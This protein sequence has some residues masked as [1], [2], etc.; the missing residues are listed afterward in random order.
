M[1]IST[2]SYIQTA[3]MKAMG[4]ITATKTPTLTAT[5][6]KTPTVTKTP[7]K[8][9]TPT[10][11]PTKTNTPTL[12]SSVTPTKT[13]TVDPNATKTPTPTGTTA[14]TFY[15]SGVLMFNNQLVSGSNVQKKIADCNAV[16]AL[17]I[18]RGQITISQPY[19]VQYKF[20]VSS[21][22]NGTTTYGPHETTYTAP[23]TFLTDD[24]G[25]S[26]LSCGSYDISFYKT[27]P[28]GEQLLDEY[29]LSIVQAALPTI[30]ST[31]TSTATLIPT[32]T[33]TP[34]PAQLII[35]PTSTPIK[36]VPIG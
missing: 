21:S 36:L 32:A 28:N 35:L 11:T 18:L 25:T 8:T 6:S 31:N 27:F 7:T 16:P 2:V 22:S 1:G 12:T 34:T 15:A 10:K 23:G 3:T 26:N 19:G 20:V 13:N 4:I 24:M 33:P 9:L 5:A 30:A 14:P 29:T 17:S